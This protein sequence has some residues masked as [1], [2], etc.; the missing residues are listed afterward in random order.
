V[1]DGAR[2]E[3]VTAR[4]YRIR[5][6]R[7]QGTASARRFIARGPQPL[8]RGIPNRFATGSARRAAVS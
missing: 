4:T 8:R 3:R 2:L 6:R 5:Q 7:A 1:D